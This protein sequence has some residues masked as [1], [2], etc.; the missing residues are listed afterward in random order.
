MVQT[1]D[2]AVHRAGIPA[3]PNLGTPVP[4]TTSRSVSVSFPPDD[5]LS[6]V[7]EGWFRS[8]IF[9][10]RLAGLPNA[11]DPLTFRHCGGMSEGLPLLRGYAH[12][13]AWAGKSPVARVVREPRLSSPAL[14]HLV[15]GAECAR[16]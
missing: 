1:V 2:P 7:A 10:A 13:G 9:L 12:S 14:R 4:G 6:N 16:E 3:E 15:S 8:V 5:N 11:D